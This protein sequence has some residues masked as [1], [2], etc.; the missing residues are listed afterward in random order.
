MKDNKEFIKGVYDK[1]EEY[2]KDEKN[3]KL[4]ND[5]KQKF[6][7]SKNLVKVLSIAAVCAIVVSGGLVGSNLIKQNNNKNANG[8]IA[9]TKTSDK[10]TLKTVDNFE[11]F[12]NIAKENSKDT[13]KDI[14]KDT[15]IVDELLKQDDDFS[16]K[17]AT[18][19]TSTAL[20]SAGANSESSSNSKQESAEN[21]SK[22]NIQVENVDEADLVKT[23][24]KYIYYVANDNVVIV[25]IN[26]KD[27]LSKVAQINYKETQKEQDNDKKYYYDYYSYNS[28][29]FKPAELYVNKNKLIVLGNETSYEYSKGNTVKETTNSIYKRGIYRQKTVAIIYDTTNKEEP[30][31]IRKVEIEGN[32]V[33]S[34][35]IDNNIYFVSNKSINQSNILKKEIED[36]NED[37]YKPYYSDTAIDKEEKLI[38]FNDIYYFEDMETLNYLTLG[39]FNLD[40]DKEVDVKTF[41]GAGE[42]IYSSTENMYIVKSKSVYDIDTYNNLGQDTKILKFSLKNGKI[43]FKAEADIEGGINN[44]FSMDEHNGYFRIAT[45]IG[46]VSWELDDYS[47]SNSLY[48]LD[49]NLK[50]VGRLDGIA[51]GEK[52]YSVRY[53]GNRAY[54]VTF[55]EMDPLFVIDLS[56]VNNPKILGELKIP[57]YSTYLHP[58]DE[59]HLI[60]FGYDTKMNSSENG[61]LKNGLKMSMF[62]ITDLNNPKELFSIKIGDKNTSS[63]LTDNHKALLFSKEKNLIAFPIRTYEKGKSISKAQVYDIDLNKGFTLRGEIEHTGDS[64]SYS[65][66]RTIERIIYSKDVFYTLSKKLIKA[67]D[68][69]TLEE[70]S[71]LEL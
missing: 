33:S 49:E 42:D 51:K 31:E 67:T 24:G 16:I 19:S 46:K 34:R 61:V 58:Y 11:N 21:Y 55:K 64:N 68:M 27:K 50:E 22:T 37:E 1:Y 35:M 30:K 44:Q 65:Y 40:N 71:K 57:G 23:D 15:S 2:K 39:G 28:N 43:D 13:S 25:D 62:D 18:S 3:L 7:K 70:I 38:D 20:D 26:E 45:T 66:Q 10:I 56:D 4:K 17:S 41:L 47:S 48:I 36:L 12:Y 52:I 9:K 14:Y 54:I 29:G 59:T 53:S 6:Y 8:E 63:E 60:G 69:N 32:Y 5:N